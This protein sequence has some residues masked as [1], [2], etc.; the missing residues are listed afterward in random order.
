MNTTDSH[1]PTTRTTLSRRRFGSLVLVAGLALAACGS[2][3]AGSGDAATDGATTSIADPWSRQPAEGQTTSAVYGVVTNA[4]EDDITVIGA[5]T[6]VAETVELHQVTMND[7]G[8][9]SMSEKEGGY[10]IEAGAS[11][12]FEPGGPHIMLL[13][14]D[15][16]TYPDSVDVTLEFD[17]G[18]TLDFTAE[19]REIGADDEMDMDEMDDG[20]MEMDG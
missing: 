6:S 17:D 8:Q 18:S 7:E 3:D 11:F 13:G 12:T 19:V 20:D 1:Q 15:P 10:T 16:A 4:G 9:M 2:D 14:I 5:T